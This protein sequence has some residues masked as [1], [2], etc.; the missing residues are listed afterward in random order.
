MLETAIARRRHRGARSKARPKHIYSIWRKMQVEA[1]R[2]RSAHGHPRG[3]R[4]G[5]HRRRLLCGAR[6]RALAVAIHSRASSTTTSPPRRTT[7]TA[8]STPR[9][10]ARVIAGRNSNPHARDACQFRARRRR[11]LA[12][13]GRRPRRSGLRAQDQPAAR[14]AGAR[15]RRGDSRDFLER[16]R[17]DLFQDRVYV[18]SPKGEIVDVPVGG[19]PLDFAYQVHTDLG[20][21]TRGAKVNGRM[22]RLDYQL[23]NSETVEIIAAKSPQPSRDWLLR[24]PASLRAPAIA[25]RSA[26]GSASRTPPRTRSRAARMLEREIQRLGVNSPP[27]PELLSELK[28]DEHRGAARGAGARRDQRR[29]SRGRHSAPAACARCPDRPSPCARERPC[30]ASR[31]SRC[32]VSAICSRRMRDA[33]SPCRPS[34]SSATSPSAA[35]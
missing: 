14:A 7:S 35:A 25:T 1:A 21:R 6:D 8:R 23:K 18:L 32:R 19:T 29:A 28:L 13:Q 17:V 12:L 22:V 4:A 26:R 30:R 15:R 3:A 2:L 5:Q 33:A 31:K 16:M 27:M 11:A 24:S 34:R 9:S 10:S 20:H